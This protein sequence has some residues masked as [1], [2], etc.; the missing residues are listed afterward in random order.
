[1]GMFPVAVN[2]FDER[3]GDCMAFDPDGAGPNLPG[4]ILKKMTCRNDECSILMSVP[5]LMSSF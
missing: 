2:P 5:F 3:Q 4:Q 1:M